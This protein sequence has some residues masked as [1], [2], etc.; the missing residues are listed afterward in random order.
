METPSSLQRHSTSVIDYELHEKAVLVGG[1]RL[2]TSQ[3]QAITAAA[4][5]R[6]DGHGD[7]SEKKWRDLSLLSSPETGCIVMPLFDGINHFCAASIDRSGYVFI[8]N[9]MKGHHELELAE[10]LHMFIRGLN[11]IAPSWPSLDECMFH[12]QRQRPQQEVEG[13]NCAMFCVW[14]QATLLCG[15]SITESTKTMLPQ[16][17]QCRAVITAIREGIERAYDVRPADTVTN[18]E[19]LAFMYKAKKEQHQLQDK[20]HRQQSKGHQEEKTAHRPSLTPR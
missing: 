14:F 5:R 12:T 9:S 19:A 8:Y 7:P 3:V 18:A 13:I 15:Y 17:L 10:K 20:E 1:T 4:Q 11:A 6:S 2:T 16:H